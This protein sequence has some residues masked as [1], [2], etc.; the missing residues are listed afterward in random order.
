[1]MQVRLCCG[2]LFRTDDANTQK[3]RLYQSGEA[4]DQSGEAYAVFK[5]RS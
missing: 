3:V 5:P 2:S 1:M 4:Y